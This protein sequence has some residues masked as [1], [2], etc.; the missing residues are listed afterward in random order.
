M[1]PELKDVRVASQKPMLIGPRE[2]LALTEL[3][4]DQLREW[5][6]RRVLIRPDLPATKRG[7]EAK[8]SWNTVLLL[9]L[10]TVLHK[11]FHLELQA[12]RGLL[13]AMRNVLNGVPFPSLQGTSLAIHDA[14]R[15]ELI[16]EA[17]PVVLLEDGILLSLR[18]HLEIISQG[19]PIPELERQLTLFPALPTSWEISKRAQAARQWG[20]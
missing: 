19:F 1:I 4:P 16:P 3:S 15:C 5:T 9:R 6:A 14:H 17:S 2:V 7:S 11:R 12:N 13:A 8:F 18:R 20:R 10:A